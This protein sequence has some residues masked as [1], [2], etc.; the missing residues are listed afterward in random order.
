MCNL[1]A[2]SNSIFT[3]T[4]IDNVD[5]NISSERCFLNFP[6]YCKS[7][8]FFSRPTENQ[9]LAHFNMLK[10]IIIQFVIQIGLAI[11]FKLPASILF[12]LENLS[13]S[14]AQYS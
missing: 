11:N 3:C 10:A 13:F 6:K 12:L 9:D 7:Y 14:I 5:K 4:K 2:T 8:D 1:L